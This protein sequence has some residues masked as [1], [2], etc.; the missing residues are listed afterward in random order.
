MPRIKQ[1]G[2]EEETLVCV[3]LSGSSTLGKRPGWDEEQWMI[4]RGNRRPLKRLFILSHDL[5]CRFLRASPSSGV[6]ARV[7]GRPAELLGDSPSSKSMVL[8]EIEAQVPSVNQHTSTRFSVHLLQISLLGR[9]TLQPKPKQ[10]KIRPGM[11]RLMCEYFYIHSGP[12]CLYLQ[13]IQLDVGVSDSSSPSQLRLQRRL[14]RW[15]NPSQRQ[16]IKRG[17]KDPSRETGF[18]YHRR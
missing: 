10:Q 11:T 5:R 3:S 6:R 2:Q 8:Y 1:N 15:I 18:T 16:K 7:R 17:Q 13:P 14:E 9:A 4:W 12:L